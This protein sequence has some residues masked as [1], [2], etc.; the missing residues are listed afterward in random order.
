MRLRVISLVIVLS[1][2]SYAQS[3]TIS[4]CYNTANGQMRYVTSSA[5]CRGGENFVSWNS[6]GPK[7][8]KGDKGDPGPKGDTGAKGD[9]GD[10]GPAGPAGSPGP[11]GGAS[12]VYTTQA[13]G[14]D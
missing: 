5:A 6:Q 13:I 11:S 8:D 10:P 3:S 9:T 4:A 14:E 2:V 1:A 7:G 12:D